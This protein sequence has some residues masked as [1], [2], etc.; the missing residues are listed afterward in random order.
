MISAILDS[1]C[2]RSSLREFLVSLGY[3]SRWNSIAIDFLFFSR[4]SS[5]CRQSMWF[6]SRR[7]VAGSCALVV[8]LLGDIAQHLFWLFKFSYSFL[9]AHILFLVTLSLSAAINWSPCAY[10][11]MFI[12]SLLHSLSGSCVCL[13]VSAWHNSDFCYAMMSSTI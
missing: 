3:T 1:D 11:L 12:Y 13:T 9:I 4:A 8:E 6:M 2:S 7:V 10:L 5:T